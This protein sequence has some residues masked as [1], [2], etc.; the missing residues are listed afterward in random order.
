VTTCKHLTQSQAA[1]LINRMEGEAVAL[2]VWQEPGSRKRFDDL[3]VRPEMASPRQLRM[4]E[5]MWMAVSRQSTREEKER[6]LNKFIK[7]IAGI[8][9]ITF[10][11]PVEAR[12]VIRAIRAMK[13]EA[14][15]GT[16]AST[17]A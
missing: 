17:G 11:G 12:K 14:H 15:Y 10:L 16:V 4:L 2:G 6:A 13:Q 9:H 3:G 5:A 7:R 8:D 1:E